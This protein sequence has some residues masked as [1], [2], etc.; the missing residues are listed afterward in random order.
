MRIRAAAL[1]VQNDA[2][3]VIERH[4]AGKHYF[5]FPGGGVEPGETPEQAAVREVLEELGLHIQV[6]RRVAEVWFR[7]ERQDHFLAEA[8]GGTFGTGKGEE[9]NGAHRPLHGTY[10]P[11]W[12]P[13]A[14]LPGK[15]VLPAGVAAIAVKALTDGWPEEVAILHEPQR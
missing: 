5:T 11:L 1:I 15:L 10:R 3:A 7:G 8:T 13:V 12:M 6:V 14:E 9:F 4:R 2:I